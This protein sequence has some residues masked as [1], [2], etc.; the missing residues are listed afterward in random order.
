MT[1]LTTS[2]R[3]YFEAT[4][5]RLLAQLRRA[6]ALAGEPYVNGPMQPL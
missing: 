1:T 5:T 6:I 2:H 4:L 3:T